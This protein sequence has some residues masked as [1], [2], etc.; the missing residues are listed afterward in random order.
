MGWEPGEKGTGGVRDCGREKRWEIGVL[1]G[2]KAREIEGRYARMLKNFVVQKRTNKSKG[3]KR[4]QGVG[5]GNARY[6]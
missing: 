3:R 2:W 1:E 6:G 4:K 5:A